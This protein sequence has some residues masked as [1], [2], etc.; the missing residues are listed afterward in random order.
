MWRSLS[1]SPF[2]RFSPQTRRS[3]RHQLVRLSQTRQVRSIHLPLQGRL[4]FPASCKLLRGRTRPNL[5][6][7]IQDWSISRRLAG[8]PHLRARRPREQRKAECGRFP[9]DL[10]H[11]RRFPRLSHSKLRNPRGRN[12]IGRLPGTHPTRN[13]ESRGN[14]TYPQATA[15]SR[16][17]PRPSRHRLGNWKSSRSSTN[18]SRAP[19]RS[20]YPRSSNPCLGNPVSRTRSSLIPATASGPPL[21]SRRHRSGRWAGPMQADGHGAG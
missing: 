12:P 9:S 14:A 6:R 20:R 15:I 21:S 3:L 7:R 1:R 16:S 8:R 19:T 11:R 18:W 2:L 10:S 5:G 13:P 4:R 17:V